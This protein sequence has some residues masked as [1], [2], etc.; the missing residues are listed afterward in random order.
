MRERT[1]RFV[2]E[3]WGDDEDADPAE[4][5]VEAEFELPDGARAWQPASIPWPVP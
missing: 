2:I 3:V 5:T 1:V 4:V